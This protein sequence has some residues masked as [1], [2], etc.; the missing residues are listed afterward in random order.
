MPKKTGSY[1]RLNLLDAVLKRMAPVVV[2]YSGGLDSSFLLWACSQALPANQIQA[3]TFHSAATPIR[4]IEAA[5]LTA[6]FLNVKHNIYP[7]PEMKSEEFLA[8]DL[9]RC[10]YCKRERF[11]FLLSLKAEF[12]GTRFIEGS[13]V[14]DLDDFRPGMRA[15]K[16]AGIDSPLLEAG[17]SKEDINIIAGDY[18]LPFA[19]KKTESCL[20]TRIKTGH[21]IETLIL[22]QVQVAEDAIHELGFQ[23]VRVR[24]HAGEARLEFDQGDLE[25]A[26]VL[27]R[28][29]TRRVKE[30]GFSIVSLDFEGYKTARKEKI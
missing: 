17:I 23:L 2:A 4:E 10:Y 19:G 21:R 14:D 30:C 16:E 27:R 15:L 1:N 28:E 13:V 12:A 26:F 29:I 20:A 8:N 5:E 9:L 22:E 7:G 24:W 18:Y 11:A 25:R 6:S 3:V